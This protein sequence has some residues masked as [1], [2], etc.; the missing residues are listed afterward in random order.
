MLNGTSAGYGLV[1]MRERAELHGGTLEAGRRDTGGF[2]V[3]ARLPLATL[4][5]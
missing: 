3:K 1:G 5:G 2:G 4:V